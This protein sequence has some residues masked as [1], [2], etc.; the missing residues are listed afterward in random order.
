MGPITA[1]RPA[2]SPAFRSNHRGTEKGTWYLQFQHSVRTLALSLTLFLGCIKHTLAAYLCDLF[3]V[4]CRIT[5][6]LMR[7][8]K[9]DLSQF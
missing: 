7:L 3:Y 9:C 4:Y 8:L 6:D 1:P 2:T 5:C